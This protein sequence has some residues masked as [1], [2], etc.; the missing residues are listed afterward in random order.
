MSNQRIRLGLIGCG[1]M[2]R[3]V[4]L[5]ALASIGEF[6]V[7]AVAESDERA[8]AEALKLA[9]AARSFVDYG[10]LLAHAEIDAVVVALPNQLHAAAAL[11]AL[12]YRYHVYL[13]KPIG[14]SRDDIPQLQQAAA[15]DDRIVMVGFNYRYHPLARQLRD[16]MHADAVG[17]IVGARSIFTTH[18]RTLPTWKQTRQT[19]GGALLDLASHHVD[20]TR[21]MFEQPI[22]RIAADIQSIRTED[23]VASVSMRLANGVV[24]QSLFSFGVAARDEWTVYG[25]SGILHLDRHYSFGVSIDPPAAESRSRVAFRR[26]GQ[27]LRGPM[28]LERLRSPGRDPSF[29]AALRDF[30]SA[31]RGQANADR[32]L[33]A[34]G[35][36]SLEIVLA[37]EFSAERGQPVECAETLADPALG[38]AS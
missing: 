16:L 11:A 5:P 23:D 7:T 27:A 10:D 2:A 32:P 33:L 34:D 6:D 25:D 20:L 36:R 24:V 19:G 8:R 30:A 17:R 35:C 13:E 22:V 15:R 18:E 26:I 29:G 37:A 9:P 1:A 12:S 28:L 38:R 21:F 3:H 14:I 31:I 4:H